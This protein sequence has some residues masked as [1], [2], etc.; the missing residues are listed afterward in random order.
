MLM[1]DTFRSHIGSSNL[2]VVQADHC[3]REKKNI[4]AAR[5][6]P[7]C[8][9]STAAADADRRRRRC[10]AADA[11]A[12]RLGAQAA[13]ARYP[14][15]H[16]AQIPGAN[17][18]GAATAVA[19]AANYALRSS[20]KCGLKLFVKFSKIDFVL[21]CKHEGSRADF[22]TFLGLFLSHGALSGYV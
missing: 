9:R 22:S 17:R 4:A 21:G 12:A 3:T 1:F 19:R 8:L 10:G 15:A 14:A 11:D 5:R 6:S 20:E 2:F 16:A 13:G 18:S 7:A